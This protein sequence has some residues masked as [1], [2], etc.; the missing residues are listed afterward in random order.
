MSSVL[1]LNLRYATQVPLIPKTG[2]V[3]EEVAEELVESILL[4]N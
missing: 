1:E 2:N 3:L 4:L